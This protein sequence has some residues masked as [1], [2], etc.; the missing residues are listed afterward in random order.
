MNLN[1]N[2][3]KNINIFGFYKMDIT[4][5]IINIINNNINYITERMGDMYVYIIRNNSKLK[6]ILKSWSN[7]NELD[8]L[9][10]H[11]IVNP[12][13]ILSETGYHIKI[14]KRDRT[15]D[16]EIIYTLEYFE[17]Y[18]IPIDIY[19][20]ICLYLDKNNIDNLL[21][22][23]DT[24]KNQLSSMTENIYR[25]KTLNIFPKF[26]KYEKLIYINWSELY[27]DIMILDILDL[28][29]LK[30]NFSLIYKIFNDALNL[31]KILFLMI[32]EDYAVRGKYFYFNRL[33]S[34]NYFNDAFDIIYPRMLNIETNQDRKFLAR[35]VSGA[36]E[37]KN[38]Y[39][40]NKIFNIPDFHLPGYNKYFLTKILS[41]GDPIFFK[42]ILKVLELPVNRIDI[43]YFRASIY[44]NI[45]NKNNDMIKILID[46]YKNI[47]IDIIL[48]WAFIANDVDLIKILLKYD[49]V[50]PS[51][52]NNHLIRHLDHFIKNK[53]DRDEIFHLLKSHPN[54]KYS[55]T[56]GITWNG[57][58]TY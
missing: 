6:I 28:D 41:T 7:V 46:T 37:N 57:I 45:E 10:I 32:N 53:E 36:I 54:Y 18:P 34:Q 43:S 16:N 17:L 24:I 58:Y 35:I 38:L 22:T 42:E 3:I 21:T 27:E 4:S 2:Y 50:F 15:Y 23:S 56:I 9:N 1:Y 30:E 19:S 55:G 13:K 49:N 8:K 25:T 52:D 11:N 47:D 51:I 29:L 40:I 20:I 26:K 39:I 31:S 48:L 5:I 12:S 33:C 44:F 14:I